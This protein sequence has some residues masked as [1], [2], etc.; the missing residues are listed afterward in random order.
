MPLLGLTTGA[1]GA[2]ASTVI[3]EGA[4]VLPVASVAVALITVPSGSGVAGVKV[5]SP[6]PSAVT[7]AMRLPLPSVSVTVLPGSAVPTIRVPLLTSRTG[8]DGACES[9]VTLLPTLA[10][11]EPSTA[12]ALTTVPLGSGVAGV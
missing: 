1:A 4:L 12:T 9:M 10:L 2:T 6:K 7:C 8:A 5:Q 11:P 3:D